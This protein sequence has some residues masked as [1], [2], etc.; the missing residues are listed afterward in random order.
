[1]KREAGLVKRGMHITRFTLHDLRFTVFSALSNLSQW[2]VAR[3]GGT[4]KLVVFA[5]TR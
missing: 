2:A 5:P 4:V 1:V 3:L